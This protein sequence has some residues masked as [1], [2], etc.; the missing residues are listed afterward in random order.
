MRTPSSGQL[1]CAWTRAGAA[2]RVWLDWATREDDGS[3]P[4]CAAAKGRAGYACVSANSECVDSMNGPGY[5]CRCKEG[6]KGNPY[7]DEGGC[8]SK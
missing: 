4:A 7:K 2:C 6:F 3:A 1:T 8:A 5:F